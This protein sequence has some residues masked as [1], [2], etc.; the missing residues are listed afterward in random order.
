MSSTKP[1]Q[2][3]EKTSL[4]E[5]LKNYFKGARAE[6]SKVSWPQ[7]DQIIAETVIVLVVVTIF[8]VI[9]FAMDKFFE[10]TLGF[11]K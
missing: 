10:F 6:W 4:Q 5:D 3:E 8:T 2:A 7:K 9:V 11:I 1:K